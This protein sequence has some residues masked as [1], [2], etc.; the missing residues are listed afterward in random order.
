MEKNWQFEVR[1]RFDKDVLI[2]PKVLK[3]LFGVAYTTGILRSKDLFIKYEDIGYGYKIVS[4]RHINRKIS[5]NVF[6]FNG[7]PVFELPSSVSS[8]FSNTVTSFGVSILGGK[9]FF[10]VGSDG[11]CLFNGTRKYMILPSDF[12]RGRYYID[13]SES[14]DTYAIVLEKYISE[15]ELKLNTVGGGVSLPLDIFDGLDVFDIGDKRGLN[16][17]Y[18]SN[19]KYLILLKN[20]DDTNQ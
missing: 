2:F 1:K 12:E 8:K 3:I 13:F 18:D 11:A 6:D 19:E 10:M 16:C 15:D 20:K 9:I 14:G 17:I 5:V 7:V 4:S